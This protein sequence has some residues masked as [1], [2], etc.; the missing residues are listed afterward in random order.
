VE[1]MVAVVM[2]ALM[3]VMVLMVGLALLA[4]LALLA[5]RELALRWWNSV[6]KDRSGSR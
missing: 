4:L 6:T 3:A 5:V 2:T 1:L